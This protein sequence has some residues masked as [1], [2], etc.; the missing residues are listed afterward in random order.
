[1]SEKAVN[2]IDR[3]L[4]ERLERAVSGNL[5]IDAPLDELSRW[6]IGGPAALMIVA[7]TREHVRDVLIAMLGQPEP[8]LVVGETSNLLFD[9][10]GFDGV[11]LRL[12]GEFEQ[13]SIV[14]AEVYA[15]GAVGVPSLADAVGAAGLTGLE[16]IA[17]I[18][19]TLGGLVAMNG[20]T[21]RR[22]IGENVV[23]VDVFDKAGTQRRIPA[24]S[25][26]FSYRTSMFQGGQYVI[27]GVSLRLDRDNSETIETEI[28]R[29]RAERLTKFP[30]DMPNCGSTFLS[31][32]SMYEEIGP[33]GRAIEAA[34][35]K[36]MRRGGAVVSEQHANF[37][38]NTGG[39]TSDDVLRIV[40]E[41]QQTV[42]NR[43]GYEMACEARFVRADGLI[44]PAHRAAADRWADTLPGGCFL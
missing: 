40:W 33:P 37:I 23:S 30:S 5:R 24:E 28:A 3:K 21:Q 26:G 7:E 10:A 6:H 19:G 18:P 14:G 29:I 17:G 4:I 38:N 31:D 43:T 27:A 36:G 20:G 15:G 13:I 8:F 16:H 2:R 39:A 34:G 35:L 11:I 42:L 32:P 9:S 25:A 44:V 12:A 41:V 1:M 22:G